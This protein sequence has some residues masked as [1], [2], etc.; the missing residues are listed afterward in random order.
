MK[1]LTAECQNTG[2]AR[3]L[4]KSCY[5]TACLAVNANK[6]TWNQ[7]IEWGM[8][9]PARHAGHSGGLFTHKLMTR[10]DQGDAE[11]AEA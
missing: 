5:Q 1:C 10:L 4:C 9:T 2:T 7:L 6:V 3:G 11:R 8:A